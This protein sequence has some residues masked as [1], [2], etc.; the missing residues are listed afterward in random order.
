M[1]L[2][3]CLTTTATFLLFLTDKM[4]GQLDGHKYL[5]DNEI[6]LLIALLKIYSTDR[7]KSVLL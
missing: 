2:H 3:D 1:V 7:S 6:E 5:Q 4:L